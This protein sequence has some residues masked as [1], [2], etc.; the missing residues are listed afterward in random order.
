[1][2]GLRTA[3]VSALACLLAAC[4]AM[5]AYQLRPAI[6]TT[7]TLRQ[8][9][10]LTVEQE[11]WLAGLCPFGTPVTGDWY[12][13]EPL[14]LIVRPGYAILHNDAA[15]TPI[16]VCERMRREDVHGPLTGR[17]GWRTDPVLCAAA[18]PAH[19]PRGAVDKDYVGSGYDRGHLAPNWNQ[20]RDAQRKRETFYFSNAAPQVGRHF[21][22]SVWQALE[23]ELTE[24]VRELESFWTI[25]GVLY[26]DEAED[27]PATA[28]GFIQIETIG[29]GA[30]HVP[31]HFYK[32]VI[33]REHDALRAFAVAMRNRDHA[34]ND[35]FRDHLTSIRWIEQR[36]DIDFLPTLEP[37]EADALE[38]PTGVP[39]R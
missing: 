9:G 18:N 8:S 26:H 34:A 2:R 10:T 12:Q 4:A 24:W 36:L 11:A 16:W 15:K 38:L 23:G 19:C 37:A 33:W 29:T 27:D 32:I 13:R 25:T 21:N 28:D 5:P 3:L 6:H 7:A 20:R 35:S 17:D 30:V 14:T 22:Q 31:T 39:F 1:M